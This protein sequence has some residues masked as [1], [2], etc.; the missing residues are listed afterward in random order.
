MICYIFIVPGDYSE[1]SDWSECT[2]TC[3]GGEMT[4]TRSCTNPPP[5][6]DGPTCIEQGLGAADETVNCNEDSCPSKYVLCINV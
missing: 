3:G 2:A 1:W 5:E 4:R 6:H